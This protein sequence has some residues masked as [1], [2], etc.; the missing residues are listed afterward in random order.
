[1]SYS[2]CGKMLAVGTHSHE[3][4][5]YEAF[6]SYAKKGE[7]R[8]HKSYIT[9]I[10]WSIDGKYIRSCSGDYCALFWN[11]EKMKE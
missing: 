10:D 6:N 1:M 2:P 11:I 8:G 4:Y 9:D 7:L 3:I 5:I